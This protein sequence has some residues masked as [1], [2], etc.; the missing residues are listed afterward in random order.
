M[1]KVQKCVEFADELNITNIG[2]K[3]VYEIA[4]SKLR[5][6]DCK[7]QST[8]YENTLS[9]TGWIYFPDD[10]FRCTKQ[11]TKIT[12]CYVKWKVSEGNSDNLIRQFTI[13]WFILLLYVT[14]M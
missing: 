10:I 7:I 4:T 3:E 8:D 14:R 13:K 6:I 1:I 12:D 5:L 2:E 11:T 9:S